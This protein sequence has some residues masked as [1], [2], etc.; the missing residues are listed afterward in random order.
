[1]RF[2]RV[3]RERMRMGKTMV[4]CMSGDCLQHPRKITGTFQ[5]THRGFH[6]I[7]IITSIY[8]TCPQISKGGSI[9]LG[10]FTGE[11]LG[12]YFSIS[13]CPSMYHCCWNCQR[14]R[15]WESNFDILSVDI[16]EHKLQLSKPPQGI[17]LNLM[18]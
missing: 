15:L 16:S 7:K 6:N 18:V 17:I 13:D 10:L 3:Y 14:Q 2:V 12:H 4:M 11:Y 1:M 9:P 5:K 8:F